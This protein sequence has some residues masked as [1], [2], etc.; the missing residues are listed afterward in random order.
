MQ[1]RLSTFIE[2]DLQGVN[3]AGEN[4]S[5]NSFK[6]ANLKGAILKGATLHNTE[7]I[8]A[9]LSG[10]DLSGADLYK[11]DVGNANLSGANLE[12]A[13][14]VGAILVHTR[15]E[16]YYTERKW[17]LPEDLGANLSSANLN[18]ANLNGANL[19]YVNFTACSMLHANFNGAD[20]RKA[21]LK[22]AVLDHANLVNADLTGA[23][24]DGVN[25]STANCTGAL[26]DKGLIPKS[27]TI[28]LGTKLRG[29][30]LRGADLIGVNLAGADLS[31]ADLRGANLR[32]AK[33]QGANL[34]GANL[35]GAYLGDADLSDATLVDTILDGANLHNIIFD[36]AS[37][38]NIS[39]VGIYSEDIYLPFY[40]P[41]STS[42]TQL[43]DQ[44][45]ERSIRSVCDNAKFRLN[46]DFSIKHLSFAGK[47]EMYYKGKPA[48]YTI[49]EA[50][51]EGG[52]G[53]VRTLVIET[54]EGVHTCAIKVPLTPYR[55]EDEDQPGR[56]PVALDELA[57]LERF[58]K[59]L[60]CEGI[61]D[62]IADPDG[63]IIMPL[64][65]GSIDDY[66]RATLQQ[67][68]DIVRIVGRQLLCLHGHG[69]RYYDIKP[70]NILYFCR[71]NG[72]VD[73]SLADIGSIVPVHDKGINYVAA[74]TPPP[75][76]GP[77]TVPENLPGVE[78]YYTFLLIQLIYM[79]TGPSMFFP[80]FWPD[81]TRPQ[82][83]T[84]LHTTI[85]DFHKWLSGTANMHTIVLLDIIAA[86]GRRL[87][88]LKHDAWQAAP[89]EQPGEIN[90]MLDLGLPPFEKFL[91]MLSV[92]K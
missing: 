86:M 62:I 50:I 24:L 66:W 54:H 21:N 90:Q 14:L 56:T 76:M 71:K 53:E 4:L 41:T 89:M 70:V 23:N 63:R 82:Y 36:R 85:V 72:H 64:A 2:A 48:R 57:V 34:N 52:F 92:K 65:N 43:K 29:A 74:T 83:I 81:T 45:P 68:L 49:G 32:G 51:G 8:G 19:R 42:S 59:A 75:G 37:V 73:I 35:T 91:E 77:G 1:K 47:G 13:S 3:R 15:A 16:T 28:K 6:K 78:T 10:A 69:I 88:S 18:Y 87:E 67:A 17:R 27:P 26:V 11:S 7:F 84:D 40:L 31:G 44:Q 33:M 30:S 38:R 25:L 58:P 22:G 9:D 60:T 46:D 55:A 79:L 80:S 5:N 39:Y 12:H 20:L 61:I